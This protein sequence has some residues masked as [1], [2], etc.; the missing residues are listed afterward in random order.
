MSKRSKLEDRNMN[1]YWE[2]V[3]PTALFEAPMIWRSKVPGGWL[4]MVA[5][6]AVVTFYPDA[7]HL[8][9]EDS[10]SGLKGSGFTQSRQHRN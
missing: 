3:A 4:V 7:K 9:D 1:I 10:D 8:W 6:S 5:D 2:K